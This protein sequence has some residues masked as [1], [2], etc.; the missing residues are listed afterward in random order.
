MRFGR[1]LCV[2]PYPP[3]IGRLVFALLRHNNTAA[4]L[5][6]ARPRTVVTAALGL[7]L[8]FAFGALLRRFVFLA[9]TNN[10]FRRIV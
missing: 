9:L 3:L 7:L 6:V 5:R 8:G 2:L 4:I 1:G 10:R